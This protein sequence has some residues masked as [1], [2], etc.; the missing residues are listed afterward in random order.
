MKQYI[1]FLLLCLSISL[2]AAQNNFNIRD[3]GARSDGKTDDAPA[4]QAAIDA[5]AKAGG[6]V[7]Y[8]PPGDYLTGPL[9]LKS[10]IDLHIEAGATLW[11]HPDKQLYFSNGQ[12]PTS[13]L[14]GNAEPHADYGL[15][16]G[17][18]LENIAVTGRGTINGQGAEYW[19][20]KEKFRPYILQ[21]RRSRNIRFEDV[22]TTGSP[23]HSFAFVDCDRINIRDIA[24]Y[25]D[26][27]SPNTDGI[28]L[29]GCSNVHISGVHMDTGDDCLV[30]GGGSNAVTITNCTFVTPWAVLWVSDGRGVTLSN[31]V[32]QCQT[33][34]KDIQKAEY[35]TVANVV[36]SGRGRLFSSLGGPAKHLSLTNITAYDFAQA[37]WLENAEN[38]TL[39]NV[40]VIRR[41]GSGSP[42]LND[43][44]EFRNV[45]GLTL[46]DVEV[47]NI[48]QGPALL[49]EEVEDLELE[50]FRAVY[51]PED[52]PA[53]ILRHTRGAYLHECRGVPETRF[54]RIEGD[55]TAEI[56]I[57]GNDLNGALVEAAE[58]VPASALP[59]IAVKVSEVIIPAAIDAGEPAPV[60]A[61]LQN[62][63]QTAGFGRASL[64][65]N[66][67]VV[68]TRWIW[69][70]EGERRR[71]DLTAGPFYRPQA[72]KIRINEHP[73]Q[74]LRLIP[75]PA[76][77]EY[78]S[79][80]P[81][82]EIVKAG[83]ELKL[84]ARLKNT[85]SY[86]AEEEIFLQIGSRR[87][88]SRSVR[89]EPGETVEI[90]F[91]HAPVKESLLL[92]SVDD[93]AKCTVKAYE[94]PL[95]ALVVALD[96][97]RA[98]DSLVYD[99]SGLGNHLRLRSNP[100]GSPP[101]IVKG[102]IG[103]GLQFNGESAYGELAG[104]RLPYPLTISMW[105]K[106]GELT[107]SS[108]GGR[109]MILYASVA[110]GNDGFG[111]EDETHIAREAGDHLVFWNR[112]GDPFE[113]RKKIEDTEQY[114][115]LTAVYGPGSAGLYINGEEVESRTG[116]E[117]GPGFPH[118]ANRIY[119]GRPTADYLRY[120]DG[121]LDEVR[122]YCEALSAEEVRRLYESYSNN[123]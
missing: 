119:L 84:R 51:F 61:T 41:F 74:D 65:I 85:G 24:L 40:K 50:G 28:H 16:N 107:P 25:N 54:L 118:Y 45:S 79:L 57:A 33:L 89:I 2:G 64:E 83:E 70:K 39:D 36:A 27:K 99:R 3:Y 4:I 47:R 15:I 123:K 13:N 67:A 108:V 77:L 58:N 17:E 109:Q 72:Y 94:D 38:V 93:Q 117:G 1:A 19:W 71:V 96:F 69:L 113:L 18:D 12:V 76:T 82:N 34:L 101:S 44:F 53:V 75:K 49:C 23:T 122:I 32:V 88:D 43:G 22:T 30:V 31:C 7:V 115:F 6:G 105:I 8:V 14:A 100:G 120:F 81:E 26:P 78:L 42:V 112:T 103:A 80:T 20:G 106:P 87:M 46:R 95:S 97:E 110:R 21:I 102:K 111:P 5:C 9:F 48:D 52:Q 59:A 68:Q 121:E 63:G 55:R 56:R 104:L 73:P 29:Y 116:L 66:S 92:F 10:N 91:T 60:S 86:P 62:T 35:V 98:T 114:Y 11:A 37:G 90:E